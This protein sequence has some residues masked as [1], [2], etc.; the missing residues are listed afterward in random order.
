MNF[1]A[2]CINNNDPDKEGKIK[3][4]IESLMWG[5]TDETLYPWARP[6]TRGIGGSDTFGISFIPENE[7]LVWIEFEDEIYWRNPKYTGAVETKQKHPHSVFKDDI[8]NLINGGWQSTYPF[9]KYI[10]LPNKVGI[11]LSSDPSNPE[12]AIFH[13]KASLFFNKEGK[14]FI[15]TTSDTEIISDSNSV[16]LLGDSGSNE[17]PAV[18]G[19]ELKT[20]LEELADIFMSHTHQGTVTSS[21]PLPPAIPDTIAWKTQLISVLSE[22]LKIN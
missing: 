20:K 3:I 16:K 22:I 5:I 4:Y 10:T 9:N 7:T 8:K 12:I 21:P 11:G 19:N 14:L 2:K 18:L 15:K 1:I 6:K 13:P 17:H